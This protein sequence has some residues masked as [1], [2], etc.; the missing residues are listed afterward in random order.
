LRRPVQTVVYLG[1]QCVMRDVSESEAV[2]K[3]ESVRKR[4]NKGQM[5]M[6]VYS[7]LDNEFCH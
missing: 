7:T 5:N 2:T 4:K 3:R 1:I 6:F